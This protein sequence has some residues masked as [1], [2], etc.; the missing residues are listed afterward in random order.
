MEI[1]FF[2]GDTVDF[3]DINAQFGNMTDFDELVKAAGKHEQKII[4][5]VDPNHTSEK[6]PW[7]QESIT[8]VGNY[9]NY[10]VWHTCQIGTQDNLPNNWVK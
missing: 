7:F 4:L 6:H 2:L 9:S 8:G 1:I 3:R 5:E 10:Y